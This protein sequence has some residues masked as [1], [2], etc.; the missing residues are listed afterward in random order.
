MCVCER[1]RGESAVV[2]GTTVKYFPV[3]WRKETLE[4]TWPNVTD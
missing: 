2:C 1:E 3:T 4:M